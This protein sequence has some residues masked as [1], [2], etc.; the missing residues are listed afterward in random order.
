MDR[1]TLA[2]RIRDWFDR[3]RG[4]APTAKSIAG[5]PPEAP[6]FD[7]HAVLLN[8]FERL[9]R[10]GFNLGLPEL[11]A[12]LDAVDGG[13]GADGP[14]ALAE[15]ARLLWCKSRA[16]E[17]EFDLQWDLV[18]AGAA[19]LSPAEASRKPEGE[20]EQKERPAEPPPFESEPPR[21]PSPARAERAAEL[22]ALPIRSPFV[23][24]AAEG[25][26]AIQTY[27]PVARRAMVYAWRYLRRPVPDGPE[28]VLDIPATVKQAAQQ[29]FYL[30]PV[31]RRRERNYA[32]LILLVD[33]GGSMAPVHRFTRDLVE[34]AHNE[35]SMQTVETYYF[36]NVPGD[37]VYRDPHLTQRIPLGQAL[38]DCTGDT[39]VLVVSDG[40]AARGHRDLGRIQATARFLSGLKARTN[41]IA[42]LNPMPRHRWANTSAQFIAGL[43][44][45]YPLDADGLSGAIDRV[46]GQ[47]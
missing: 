8:V 38:R 28:D 14:A 45:M 26:A 32:H 27:W 33:Q 24:A 10:T 2:Q 4:K 20:G 12:A 37:T 29:G 46:R 42:W 35:S 40:G 39:S 25:E 44:A 15:V 36:Q 7:P 30:G 11:F 19:T 9:R 47:A 41:L 34:T 21:A 3:L 16:D 6:G 18:V 22:A 1:E 31:Y 43:A 17:V 13:W 5:E 23:P